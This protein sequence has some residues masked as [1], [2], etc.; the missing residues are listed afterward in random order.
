MRNNVVEK[1]RNESTR[2]ALCWLMRRQG[3]EAPVES[4]RSQDATWRHEEGFG[5]AVKVCSARIGSANYDEK[6]VLIAS[7]FVN[8]FRQIAAAAA[9]SVEGIGSQVKEKKKSQ[10][11]NTG[12]ACEGKLGARDGGRTAKEAQ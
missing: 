10:R 4:S 5:S 11:R 12:T 6:T 3:K 7:E 8:G 9:A 2:C 1:H